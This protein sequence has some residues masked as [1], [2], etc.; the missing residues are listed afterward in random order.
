MATIRIVTS[1][2]APIARCFDLS[3][4]VELHI[5]SASHTGERVVRGV[6]TGLLKLGDEVTWQAR[7]LGVRQC[8]TSRI[9]MFER[10]FFLQDSMVQGAFRAFSHD[11]QF[12]TNDGRTVMVDL[13]RFQAPLGVLGRL[14]ESLFLKR[15]LRRYLEHRNEVLKSV[16]ESDRWRSF[17]EPDGAG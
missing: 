10:P 5:E 17:V 11:H 14:A 3:R 1:I 9:T 4:S 12:E 8:L 15:Y 6:S 13:V 7:H 16:A 2:N